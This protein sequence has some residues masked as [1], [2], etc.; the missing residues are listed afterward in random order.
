MGWV[1]CG[2]VWK[3]IV[4]LRSMRDDL[5]IA[6][7]D[8]DFGVGVIRKTDKK[9]PTLP[10]DKETISQMRYEDLQKNRQFFLNLVHPRRF[11]RGIK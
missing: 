6:T 11:L 3:A 7:L 9:V 1:W 4:Y 5:E 10:F 2:D 8:C